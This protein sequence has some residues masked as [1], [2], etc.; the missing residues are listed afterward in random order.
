MY[1]DIMNF[2]DIEDDSLEITG[3]YV[4]GDYKIIKVK[5]RVKKINCPICGN[6]MY[7]KGLEERTLE[8]PILNDGFKV[9]VLFTQRRLQCSA[10]YCSHRMNQPSNIVGKYKQHTLKA[11]LIIMDKFRDLRLTAR[12]I[13]Q[14]CQMSDTNAYYLFM[15]YVTCNRAKLPR[16]LSVDEVYIDINER[17][18]YAVILMNWET[19]QIIDILS[20]RWNQVTE[21]YFYSIPYEERKNVDYVISD[22]Y[23][24]YLQFTEKYFPN[25]VSVTD[26]FHVI[27]NMNKRLV[28]YANKLKRNYDEDSL[29]YYLL[30]NYNWFLTIDER[31][32]H[33]SSK[34]KYSKKYHGKVT[35]AHIRSDFFS[36]NPN[37]MKLKKLRDKYYLFNEFKNPD[38]TP[39]NRDDLKKELDSII[40]EYTT[41]GFQIFEEVAATL[42]KYKEFIINSFVALDGINR[43][44]S[45][46]PM[47]SL[48]RKPKDYKRIARGFSNFDY[49]RARLIWATTPNLPIK[50]NPRSIKELKAKYA[51]NII[52]GKYKKK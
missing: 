43:R 30:S 13:A 15:S 1:N 35:I 39:K 42:Q 10:P 32:V 11:E 17:D 14:S 50:G 12:Q 16:V 8:H 4:E 29:E 24:P 19:G 9:R 3:I 7:S 26:S 23:D 5:Q 6:R 44:M 21:K 33:Y 41:S 18:K 31:Y 49:L 25:A 46:G 27:Q 22:M 28:Q 34:K 36:I 52:R 45:N 37:L 40:K 20:S 47:E 2:L 48:N 38:G 51:T